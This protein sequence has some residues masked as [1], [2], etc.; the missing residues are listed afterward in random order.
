MTQEV[1]PEIHAAT[2]ALQQ[3]IA[4]TE[5]EIGC[6]RQSNHRVVGSVMGTVRW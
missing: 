6:M 3:R 5:T 4:L 1:F 2:E